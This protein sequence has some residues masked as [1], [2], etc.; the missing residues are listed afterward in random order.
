M[1]EQ[2]LTKRGSLT[3]AAEKIGKDII[4]GVGE[5]TF[6]DFIKRIADWI[7]EWLGLLLPSVL[8]AILAYFRHSLGQPSSRPVWQLLLLFGICGVAFGGSISFWLTRRTLNAKHQAKLQQLELSFEGE[9]QQ[10]QHE[11]DA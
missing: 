3:D 11:L 7:I 6:K 1:D 10:L 8:A 5:E 9:K 4:Y 2:E